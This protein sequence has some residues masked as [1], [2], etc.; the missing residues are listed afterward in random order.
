MSFQ[1]IRAAGAPTF[2]LHAALAGLTLGAA[3]LPDTARAQAASPAPD[4]RA[5]SVPAGALDAA[6][7][8]FARTAGV[9]LSYDPA[10]VA[11]LTTRGLEGRHG[12]AG[13]LAA[14]LA[15]SDLEAVP[16]PGGGFS[17]RKVAGATGAAAVSGGAAL[18]TVTVSA[19]ADPAALPAP[20]AGGQVARG[21]RL[22]MLGNAD[23]FETPF[24]TK[25]YTAELVRNQGARNVN[26]MVANDPSIRTSLSAT[27]PLDQSSIRGFLTNSDAYLFDGLEGLFAY[28]NIPIQHYERLEVLKGPAAGL[29]GASGYG[30]TV[31]GSFNLVPKRATDTPVRSVTLS[32]NDRSLIGT[33][34]DIG[35]RFGTDNRFGARLNLSAED[36][37]LYDGAERRLAAAQVA[38]DY[39]G[40]RFRA[41][42]DAGYTRRSSS[43][44]FNHWLLQAGA[45]LPPPPDPKVHPKPSWET[46]DVR[47]P[48]AL[49]SA[50]WDF[51]DHW[52]AYARVGKLREHTPERRYIDQTTIDGLGR[53]TYT[54]AA[55]LLWTQ[56]NQVTDLG[57]RGSFDLGPTRHKVAISTVMQRQQLQD[58]RSQLLALPVRVVGS[59]YT[60]NLVPNPYAYGVPAVPG[61]DSPALSLDSI[62]I[63]DTISAFDE[64]LF[65]TLAAREQRIKK[66]PYAQSKLTPT[67]AAL[68]KFDNGISIYGN[69]AESLAQG[70]VAP[71]SARNAGE[72]LAPYL[73]RQHEFGLKWDRGSYGLT[74]AY[75]DIRK[76]TAYVDSDNY[77]RAAGLQRNKGMEIESFGEVAKGVRLLG[78]VAWI[79]GR[80]SRTAK[81]VSDGKKAIGVPEFTANLGLE[82]DVPSVPGL[83]LTG[84]YIYTDS[85]WV[86]LANTQRVP[87]WKRIDLGARYATRINGVGMTLRA[88]ISNLLDD[89]YWTIAGRNF[90]AVAPPRT[91]Q[92]QASFDF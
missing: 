52:T 16:Q 74:A 19:E 30:S 29:V 38:L 69:Y 22:G 91:W 70:A 28:S 13:G 44:L 42:L 27:S 49:L 45:A 76:T 64:R 88:G 71:T 2:A 57:V 81:G 77:F 84:R 78:G 72:Q 33:H 25:A 8:R 37:K 60:T 51:A 50:E 53:V 35:Q 43:P 18:P 14:L 20:Y 55:S 4:A 23:V 12:V 1:R 87:S 26:D 56:S 24:S 10:L 3:V 46:L 63:A 21:G 34:I 68:W 15:G 79:D 39:R 6:L 80:M 65:V 61:V 54:S 5:F 58:L 36:G 11:G 86:D 9:N 89:T 66:Y 40:D 85:A 47:Q 62:A 17:L 82:Y 73:S 92:L 48:F 32:A 31:G 7:N 83:T 75:F 59:L 67:V 90:I 41:V